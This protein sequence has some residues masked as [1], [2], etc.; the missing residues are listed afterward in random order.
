MTAV[1]SAQQHITP[2]GSAGGE[3]PEGPRELP[4]IDEWLS[5]YLRRAQVVSHSV[6]AFLSAMPD[7][8]RP[9]GELALVGRVLSGA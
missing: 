1:R 6:E 7:D 4:P 8:V 3:N 2:S 5:L 9:G